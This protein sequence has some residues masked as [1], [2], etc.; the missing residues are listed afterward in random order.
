MAD[1][2]DEKQIGMVLLF[3]LDTLLFLSQRMAFALE[4]I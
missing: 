2:F 4:T 3:D 1:F